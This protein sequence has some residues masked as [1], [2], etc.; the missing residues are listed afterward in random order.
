MFFFYCYFYIIL[1]YSIVFQF[2]LHTSIY[3]ISICLYSIVFYVYFYFSMSI[4]W[5][6]VFYC[7]IVMFSIIFCSRLFSS[8]LFYSILPTYSLSIYW[9]VVSLKPS[10]NCVH[11]FEV[12]VFQPQGAALAC[13]SNDLGMGQHWAPPIIRWFI[14]H[15]IHVWYIC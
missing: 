7:I 11:G 9:A 3:V 1:L 8:V 12:P 10:P 5:N 6:F 2:Y 14:S 15:R 4:I 13:R